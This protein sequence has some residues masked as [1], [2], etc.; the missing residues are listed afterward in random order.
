MANSV[1]Q[2]TESIGEV[3]SNLDGLI[4]LTSGTSALVNA[5]GWELPPGIDDIGLTA[6]DLS[7]V[8]EKLKVV[9]DSSTQDLENEILMA[10][11][12]AE[13][14]VAIGSAAARLAEFAD[15]L[16]ALLGGFGDYLDRT[17]IHKELPRRVLDLLLVKQ[18][19]DR[20]PL[21]SAILSFLNI[22][23]FKYFAADPEN[24]QVEH[25]RAIVHYDHLKAYLDDPTQHLADTY[26]WG[27]PE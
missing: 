19:S 23:E 6:L 8:L 17:N 27:T 20:A 4:Q 5:L 9:A 13:L 10:S 3:L 11:R 26:G 7:E 16:S 22:V 25:L 18:L 12:I 15:S 14:G 24:F 1:Q 2:L 21:A